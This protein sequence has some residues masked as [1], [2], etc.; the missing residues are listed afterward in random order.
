MTEC[1]KCGSNLILGPIFQSGSCNTLFKNDH[2]LY[3]CFRCGY[4]QTTPTLD[5]KRETN[6]K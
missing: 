2:L 5:Q 4:Q 3:R 1:T 6:A